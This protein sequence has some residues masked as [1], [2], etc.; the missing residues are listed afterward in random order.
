MIPTINHNYN[1]FYNGDF[2]DILWKEM[3][4]ML[5]KLKKDFR[6]K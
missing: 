2:R 6:N 4:T 1:H 3:T 5:A